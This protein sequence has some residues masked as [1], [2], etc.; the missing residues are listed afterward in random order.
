MHDL[1]GKTL[2]SSFACVVGDEIVQIFLQVGGKWFFVC[3]PKDTNSIKFSQSDDPITLDLELTRIPMITQF[4]GLEV[5]SFQEIFED[6][7]AIGFI[8]NFSELSEKSLILSK[9]LENTLKM[10]V[11]NFIDKF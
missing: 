9:S 1:T 4:E 6:K 2:E 11:S 10:G 5:L 7:K 3:S 8:V